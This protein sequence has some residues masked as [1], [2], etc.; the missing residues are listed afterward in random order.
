MHAN[1]FSSSTEN[2]FAPKNVDLEDESL[3]ET[4][5]ELEAF[6]RSVY[7]FHLALEGI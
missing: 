2:V 7:H 5:K 4:E 1:K 6:K 3:D